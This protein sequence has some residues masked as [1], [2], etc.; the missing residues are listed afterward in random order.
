MARSKDLKDNSGRDKS[1]RNFVLPKLSEETDGAE[2][3]PTLAD[4]IAEKY[5][6]SKFGGEPE[7]R[8]VPENTLD[9]LL[10]KTMIKEQLS[11]PENVSEE[12]QQN[13]I[14]YIAENMKKLFAIT[15]F[16]ELRGRELYLAMHGFINS[17]PEVTDKSLP[18]MDPSKHPGFTFPKS[19]WPAHEHRMLLFKDCQW[20]FLVPV[21]TNNALDYEVKRQT[22][23][24]FQEVEGTKAKEGTF[25]KVY[26]VRIH[27][28]HHEAQDKQATVAVKE[29][30][31]QDTAP[32]SQDGQ[33]DIGVDNVRKAWDIE[34]QA[35][36]RLSKVRHDHLIQCIAA[37]EREDK[38]Y[39]LFPWA[40]GGNL[41]GFWARPRM[42]HPQPTRKL[43]RKVLGELCGLAGALY[44]LHSY[45]Q[46][47]TFPRSTDN[48]AP[49]EGGI[50]H[51]DLKPENILIFDPHGPDDLGTLKLA[52]MG[53]AK[54]HDVVTT[55]RENPTATRHGT[56]RYE[57][58]EVKTRELRGPTSRLYDMWSMGCIML[59]FVIWL[60]HGNE[61][62]LQFSNAI[63]QKGFQGRYYQPVSNSPGQAEVHPEVTNCINQLAELPPCTANTA[64][65]DLLDIIKTKLLVVE[66]PPTRAPPQDGPVTVTP[67]EPSNPSK[68]PYRASCETVLGLLEGIVDR[69]D[70][71]TVDG[72]YLLPGGDEFTLPL[73]L[74]V[75]PTELKETVPIRGL[76]PNSALSGPKTLK[77][78]AKGNDQK[79][80]ANQCDISYTNGQQDLDIRVWEYQVDN[81]FAQTYLEM[82]DSVTLECLLPK[83]ANPEQ[84]CKKCESLDFWKRQFHIDDKL[85]ALEERARTCRFCKMRWDVSS[86][87]KNRTDQVRFDRVGS[88]VKMN[89]SDPP[90]FS[91]CRR[92]DSQ[93]PESVQIGLPALTDAGSAA[94]FAL[95]R[96]WLKDCDENHGPY[97]CN[98]QP[99]EQDAA[100]DSTISSGGGDSLEL[101]I[102][103][104]IQS[105]SPVR[106]PTRLLDV[107]ST[108]W[109]TVRL[110]ETQHHDTAADFRY[111]ALSHRW[112]VPT[113]RKPAFR[114]TADNLAAHIDGIA[115]ETLPPTFRDAVVTTRALGVRYL[116]IDSL[117]IVQGEGGDFKSECKRME[118]VFSAAYCVIA[119]TCAGDQWDGFLGKTRPPREY[120][121]LLDR[122]GGVSG[123]GAS[124]YVCQYIDDFNREVLEGEM[125]KRGW[126]LQERALARRTI[127]FA[128]QQTFFECGGGVRCET[129]TKMSN[130]LAALLGDPN[131]P[132][133]AIL[134]RTLSHSRE[135][136]FGERILY[137]QDLYQTYSRLAFTEWADRAVALEGL[138]QRL[139][140]G[141]KARGRLGILANAAFPPGRSPSLFY[142]SLLW[143]RGVDEPT[144]TRISF[145]PGRQKPPTW[146]WMAYRGGIDYLDVPFNRTEWETS[147]GVRSPW[148]P[149]HART[150]SHGHMHV[151]EVIELRATA[152]AFTKTWGVEDGVRIIYDVAGMSDGSVSGVMC[153]VMGR[154]KP[155][156]SGPVEECQ[157]V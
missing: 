14:E 12:I 126:V 106:L 69:I 145:P 115:V 1:K 29:L 11:V 108:L 23:L 47:T 17:E 140:H 54:H 19:P 62:L 27:E 91:I 15:F 152:R 7:Q 55:L 49:E 21:F 40:D 98:W 35:L 73:M 51:G 58:P 137:F 76:H 46:R 141:F 65:G 33:G 132:E 84:L 154:A 82:L 74:R 2:T 116:W 83:P 63:F 87:L 64:L 155:E 107:G 151:D 114:T 124:F 153:V 28:A 150:A 24:P 66:L 100:V 133:V 22:I 109:P 39:F 75:G 88:V 60:L 147:E 103:R 18:I 77:S 125:S 6:T 127:Y 157:G 95:L 52:D 148:Q 146:S 26:A 86:A 80:Q 78:P 31:A 43:V 56:A 57:P 121:T 48:D 44:K 16:A 41:R 37:I 111:V 122:N 85:S 50:R 118:D 136:S 25:G 94:H 117:C 144:L 129:L 119:A 93:V 99:S 96:S 97:K 68:G 5:A 92:K 36:E 72:D 134:S 120:V 9:Q 4:H 128:Q 67:A 10:T 131:F 13:L 102:R 53:L 30:I 123:V 45:N 135:T 90:V 61:K 81:H 89:E 156:G 112:G 149:S 71:S 20:K 104:S 8:Y 105:R 101:A 3:P 130:Q 79:S 138:E 34:R 139:S 59:E 70:R 42:T 142:R 38:F 143:H 113:P 32:V 110:C